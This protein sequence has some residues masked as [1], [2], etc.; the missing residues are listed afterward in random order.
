[1]N[2]TINFI[3]SCHDFQDKHIALGLPQMQ[4]F[5]VL[6]NTIPFSLIGLYSFTWL[7]VAPSRSDGW[8]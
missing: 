2:L 8:Y 5:Q 3:L 7:F 6:G 4:Q 1:I